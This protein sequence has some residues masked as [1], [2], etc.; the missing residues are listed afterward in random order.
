MCCLRENVYLRKEIS[1]DSQTNVRATYMCTTSTLRT[2]RSPYRRL[3]EAGTRRQPTQNNGVDKFSYV[4]RSLTDR[5][6]PSG[7]CKRSDGAQDAA[8]HE[9][10]ERRECGRGLTYVYLTS[11]S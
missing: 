4:A 5:L 1:I 2:R 8:I 9:Q 10:R 6:G 11:A 7:R 3:R